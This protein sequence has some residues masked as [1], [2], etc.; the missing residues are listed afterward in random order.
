M[1]EEEKKRAENIYHKALD[2]Y[3]TGEVEC[4]AD[5]VPLAAQVI[6]GETNASN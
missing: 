5:G 4:I 6:E 2:L 3:L 1:S